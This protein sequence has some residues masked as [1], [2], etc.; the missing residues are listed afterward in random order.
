MIMFPASN[1]GL[2]AQWFSMLCV[3]YQQVMGSI[4]GV[5]LYFYILSDNSLESAES[6]R[7]FLN[8]LGIPVWIQTGIFRKFQVKNQTHT[9]MIP[10]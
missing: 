4:L 6:L 9:G 2:L 7:T 3:G 8:S 10:E 1:N 5:A